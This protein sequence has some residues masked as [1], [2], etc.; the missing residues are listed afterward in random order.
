LGANPRFPNHAQRAPSHQRAA[1]LDETSLMEKIAAGDHNAL[2]VIYDRYSSMVYALSLHVLRNPQS[3]EDATQEVFLRLSRK[4]N[5][6]NAARGT[7]ASWLTV[8]ARHQAIDTVR[9]RK[10]E[11]GL[12]D[13]VIPIDR[14]N[15][16]APDY[17]GDRTTVRFILEKLPPEQRQVLD[18]A[19]FGGLTHVEIARHS[20]KPLG[21]VKSQIR[22]ALQS[23][24]RM[25]IPAAGERSRKQ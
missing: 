11:I 8:I 12:E 6:Y 18:L 1:Q 16:N 17:S 21:T 10:P 25:L 24:R 9:R 5:S 20:G 23:L 7:L 13:A 4:A 19:Y 22:L 15:T 3:A 14:P 2:M